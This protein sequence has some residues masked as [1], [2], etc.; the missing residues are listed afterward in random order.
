VIVVVVVLSFVVVAIEFDDN[1]TATSLHC[2]TTVLGGRS[3]RWEVGSW[4]CASEVGRVLQRCGAA[5][6]SCL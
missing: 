1:R 6:G 3:K 2:W 4:R 5:C